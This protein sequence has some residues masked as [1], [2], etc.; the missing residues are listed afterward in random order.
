MPL[1][2]FV[3]PTLTINDGANSIPNRS[4]V[5]DRSICAQA[6]VNVPVAETVRALRATT[7]V[8]GDGFV[9]AIDSNTLLSIANAQPGQSGGQIAGTFIQVPLWKPQDRSAQ[10]VLAGRTSRPACCLSRPMPT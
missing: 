5:N 8:L 3:N 2:N 4:L 9:E 7:N 10:D 1:G 6:S